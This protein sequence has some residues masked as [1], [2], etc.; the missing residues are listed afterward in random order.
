M[1][2]NLIIMVMPYVRG[3]IVNMLLELGAS[4]AYAVEPLQASDVWT[5]NTKESWDRV[6]CLNSPVEEIP[7]IPID[8][9][10]GFGIPPYIPSPQPVVRRVYQV[11]PRGG[12]FIVWLYG[13]GGNESY[14]ALFSPIHKITTIL[15]DFLLVF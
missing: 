4:H 9:A 15:P 1:F 11:L 14:L 6:S 13:Y 2:N 7:H 12:K 8:L 5:A 3:F 10:F